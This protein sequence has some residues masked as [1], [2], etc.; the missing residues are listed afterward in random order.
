MVQR[1]VDFLASVGAKAEALI[2]P[3]AVTLPNFPRS[4]QLDEYSCGAK[5]VYCILQYYR[6][7]C[8]PGSVERL[9]QTDSDGT[10]VSDI[11]RVLKRHGLKCRTLRKPGLRDL[12]AAIDNDCPIFVSL[13]D[14]EHYS[15]VYGYSSGHIFVMNPSLDFTEEGVGSLKCAVSKDQFR[16]MWDRW[17][18]E[19]AQ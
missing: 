10:D 12:R 14:G 6:K 17:G 16:H 5:S 1:V 3:N 2:H 18:I 13:Y 8:T 19:I 15:V 7:L 11:K 4:I 9:L